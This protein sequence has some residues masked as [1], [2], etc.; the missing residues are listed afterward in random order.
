MENMK[1]FESRQPDDQLWGKYSNTTA[2]EGLNKNVKK[3]NVAVGMKK[4]G[5][6][7]QIH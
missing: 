1:V 4:S 7:F 3:N 2:R 6:R 5:K